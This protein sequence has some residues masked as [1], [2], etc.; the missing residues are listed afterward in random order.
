MAA[1]LK[2]DELRSSLNALVK[3]YVQESIATGVLPRDFV[4]LIKHNFFAKYAYYNVR[5][6]VIEIG[7]N[8]NKGAISPYPPLSVYSFS[9]HDTEWLLD[10]FKPG[11]FHQHYYL[12]L[13]GRNDR[14]AGRDMIIMD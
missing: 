11:A 13:L 12:K 6:E 5:G 4:E 7:I 10:S 2:T 1:Y 8:E 14:S 3:R 9:I